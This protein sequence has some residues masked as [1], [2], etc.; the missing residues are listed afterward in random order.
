MV[1]LNALFGIVLSL[2]QGEMLSYSGDNYNELAAVIAKRFNEPVAIL[3]DPAFA[4]VEFNLQAESREGF[5]ARLGN[6]VGLKAAPGLPLGFSRI[7]W[8]KEVLYGS[9]RS[10]FAAQWRQ[11]SKPEILVEGSKVT[12]KGQGR[13]FLTAD[14]LEA[15]KFS[16]PFKTHWL[17]RYTPVA[18]YAEQVD[19][20]SFLSL[21]ALAMGARFVET[22]A[23]Y[24][25][26]F[27]P[28]TMRVRAVGLFTHLA[29]TSEEGYEAVDSAFRAEAYRSASDQVLRSA[30][31][32]S[33]SE[34]AYIM[35]SGGPLYTAADQR[36]RARNMRPQGRGGRQSG[37][38]QETNIRGRVDLTKPV[39]VVL[40]ANGLP[41]LRFSGRGRNSSGFI[42]F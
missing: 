36:I 12:A 16:K 25:F 38:S 28:G 35:G 14:R 15:A 22:A 40:R 3:F 10:N 13:E 32:E 26:D 37:G 9:L 19:E 2:G 20:K 1:G 29:K 39:Q 8:P 18:V 33:G 41:I 7:A 5:R 24:R 42:D 17:Y 31:A 27:D 23:E 30:F 6:V 4:K 11:S 34:A 21:L